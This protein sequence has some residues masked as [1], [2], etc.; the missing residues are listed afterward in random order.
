MKHCTW[1]VLTFLELVYTFKNP[2]FREERE[3]RGG[4]FVGLISDEFLMKFGLTTR[5]QLEMKKDLTIRR[6]EEIGWASITW[7]TV[8]LR[9]G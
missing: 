3:W 5:R 4:N 6:W 9:T 8:R 1:E 7:T 2:A